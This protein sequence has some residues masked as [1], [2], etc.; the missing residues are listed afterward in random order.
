[1][2]DWS[3]WV[4]GGKGARGGAGTEDRTDFASESGM[5]GGESGLGGNGDQ[6]V[7][8]VGSLEIEIQFE[9]EA[10]GLNNFDDMEQSRPMSRKDVIGKRVRCVFQS[11]VSCDAEAEFQ[12]RE[13]VIEL[14]T[15]LRFALRQ[16]TEVLDPV[17]GLARVHSYPGTAG[18]YR[19]LDSSS[20]L[21]LN[22]PIKAMIQP[23]GYKFVC[24][25]VLENGFVLIEGF[26]MQG[27][28]VLFM[29]PCSETMAEMQKLELPVLKAG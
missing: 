13:I 24:G 29:K 21:N 7:E 4:C 26:S 2:G 9:L 19:E 27:N 23:Y 20:D 8:G 11:D 1:V 5:P 15:G 28:G 10:E 14:E 6:A 22:S 17:T 3:W 12:E 16:E 25:I 18:L